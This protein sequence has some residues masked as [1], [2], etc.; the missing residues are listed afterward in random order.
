MEPTSHP[1]RCPG[2]AFRQIGS[3]ATGVL[4]PVAGN[5]K[6][7][8]V[9]RRSWLPTQPEGSARSAR[10]CREHH[11]AFHFNR[12]NE[13]VTVFDEGAVEARWRWRTIAL[14]EPFWV[15]YSSFAV[16]DADGEHIETTHP[17]LSPRLR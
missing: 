16:R 8:R 15:G 9:A 13:K 1:Q 4:W 5:D 3:R 10:R 6:D 12:S 2:S 11:L 17:E 14:T 7:Q